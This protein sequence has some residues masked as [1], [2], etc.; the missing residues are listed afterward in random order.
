MISSQPFLLSAVAFFAPATTGTALPQAPGAFTVK[1]FA[2]ATHHASG[3]DDIAM[4][5]GH[6]FVAWQNGVGPTGQP[7]GKHQPTASLLVDTATA[8]TSSAPGR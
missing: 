1:V 8:A 2:G 5:D 6:V 4:L 3:P 7:A